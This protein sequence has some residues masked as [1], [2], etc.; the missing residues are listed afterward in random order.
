[1]DN[2]DAK[3][4]YVYH[5]KDSYFEVANDDKLMRNREDGSYRPTYYCLKDEKTGLLWVIPMSRRVKKYKGFMQKDVERYGRCLKIVIGEYAGVDAV[6]LLQNMFPVLPEYIDHAHVI[7][8]NPVPVN[9]RLQA[10]IG[11]NF[12]E[13][14]RLHRRGIR[15][16]FT[17]ILRLEKVILAHQ[18]LTQNSVDPTTAKRAGGW[19]NHVYL[20]PTHALRLSTTK[21]NTQL[22]REAARA[23]SLPPSVG[24]PKTIA[25]GTTCGF[26]WT[27]S[28][29]IH[30]VPLSGVWDTLPPA[31]RVKAVKQ[32]LAIATAVHSVPVGEI[33]SITLRTAWYCTFDKAASLADFER[34]VALK[35]FTADEGVI[36]RGILERFYS[37]NQ[38]EP[39]LCHGDITTDNLLWHDGNVVSLLDFEHSVIAP[40]ML[41]IHSIINLA[42]SPDDEPGYAAEIKTL[43]APYLSRRSDVDLF[44]GYRVL[45]RQRFFEFFLAEPKGDVQDC[46]AYRYLKY[47]T[48][49]AA[50]AS[51]SPP[52][53]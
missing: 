24:Y 13:L 45:F 31:A 3:P 21:N 7:N 40:R 9:T 39:V 27:L 6:F 8:Q 10:I 15:I 48:L 38:A 52:K 29:R 44:M 53:Y 33:E 46:E 30:G 12:R 34:Y 11:R 35:L 42:L 41:D 16:V 51:V 47:L 4:G 2:F 49:S 25:T 14:L 5:I 22:H 26:E 17:D 43:F 50:T 19:T 18:I 20:T 1:M 23:K 28:E 36:F 37:Q 32:I